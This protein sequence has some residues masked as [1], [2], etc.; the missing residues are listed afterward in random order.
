MVCRAW[1]SHP[2]NVINGD[3]CLPHQPLCPGQNG[4]SLTTDPGCWG[5]PLAGISCGSVGRSMPPPDDTAQTQQPIQFRRG[6]CR[7]IT[8]SLIVLG[9]LRRLHAWR[10]YP[11]ASFRR[12][13]PPATLTHFGGDPPACSAGPG[14]KVYI[15]TQQLVPV[16]VGCAYF[17]CLSLSISHYRRR[18]EAPSGS[19]G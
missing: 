5:N 12:L 2:L 6:R 4:A 19:P 13:E 7:D 3:R 1:P 14:P 15:L 18:S 9:N 16:I 8:V 11:R 17:I 10:E